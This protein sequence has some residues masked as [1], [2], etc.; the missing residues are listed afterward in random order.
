MSFITQNDGQFPYFDVQLG[1]PEWTGKKVFD[2]GGNIGNILHHQDS[3][4]D[5]D[6]YWC[7]DVSRD[8]IEAGRKAAPR[9]HFVFYN[10]HNPEY[11]PRGIKCL[12]IPETENGFD[13]I[14]A[15]SVFTHTSKAE[16]IELVCQLRRLLNDS[17]RLALTFFDPHFMPAD[18][19]LCNLKYYFEQRSNALW[20]ANSYDQLEQAR[21]ANWCTLAGGELQINCDTPMTI[22]QAA[23]KEY[24]V[25]YTL[26]YLKTIFPEGKILAPV[27]PFARQHCCIITNGQVH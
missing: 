19:D 7:I 1:K 5:H 6:N 10:R 11:N 13:F 16:M 12:P 8:A 14:L 15:L 9:A 23:K 20:A 24:L 27:F 3:T 2:F 4:I 25:F 21:Q 18:S 26:E 17:G 22:Q